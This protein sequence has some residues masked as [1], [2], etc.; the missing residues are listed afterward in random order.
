M[1]LLLLHSRLKLAVVTA[2]G[3]PL[4]LLLLGLVL[5]A[6]LHARLAAGSIGLQR[7]SCLALWLHALLRQCPPKLLLRPLVG[8]LRLL[9]WLVCLL[10][11]L[12][13]QLAHRQLA[14]WH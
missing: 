1:L 4:L 7:A 9:A 8:Q 11:R 10:V 14:D 2:A 12:L 6:A 3:K 5:E 13:Q